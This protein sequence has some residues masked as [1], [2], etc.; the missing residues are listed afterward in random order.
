M[1]L[2]LY[3]LFSPGSDILHAFQID[4]MASFKSDYS[5]LTVVGEIFK[6]SFFN[7]WFSFDTYVGRCN[8]WSASYCIH[9]WQIGKECEEQIKYWKELMAYA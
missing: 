5:V 9:L 2:P 4:K 8:A 3:F 6:F 1:N 7:I